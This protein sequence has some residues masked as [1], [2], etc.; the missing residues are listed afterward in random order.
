[1]RFWPRSRKSRVISWLED[2]GKLEKSLTKSLNYIFQATLEE[3][4]PEEVQLTPSAIGLA[5]IPEDKLSHL[6]EDFPFDQAFPYTRVEEFLSEETQDA[7]LE[8][9]AGAQ[10]APSRGLI[11]GILNQPEV[12]DILSDGLGKVLLEF[13]KK[14]N[15]LHS[16]FQAAGLEKQIAQFL[17]FLLP[18]F[19]E[20]I[21]DFVAMGSGAAEVQSIL[22]NTLKILFKT[23]FGEWGRMEASALGPKSDRL[24]RAI[25]S[26]PKI[27]T[28]FKTAYSAARD[29]LLKQYRK[30]SLRE[31]I[32]LSEPELQLWIGK[33]VDDASFNIRQIHKKKPLTGLVM[34][35]LGDILD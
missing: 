3:L 33:V 23:G 7:L 26:D 27:Q 15:P 11:L 4:L 12:Q 29:T 10:A 14:I 1:M 21:A 31:F 2:S 24:R 20:R 5:R 9:I 35:I 22:R 18:G 25:A 34:E 32:G 16:V 17:T 28:V 8:F 30:E 13:H 6:I 19:T